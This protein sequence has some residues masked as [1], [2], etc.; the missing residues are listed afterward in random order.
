MKTPW[1]IAQQDWSNQDIASHAATIKAI[2][3]DRMT[4]SEYNDGGSSL[5]DYPV[6]LNLFV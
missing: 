6:C 5:P 3:L 1:L 2:D 4:V